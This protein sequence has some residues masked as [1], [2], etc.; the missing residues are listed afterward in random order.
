MSAIVGIFHTDSTSVCP[1]GFDAMLAALAHRGS[2]GT[3]QW[4][5]GPVALGQQ[6]RQ[7]TPESC[8]EQLPLYDPV[9]GLV[10]VA[11]CRLDNRHDLCDA[12]AVPHVQRTHTPDSQLLMLAYRK[13]ATH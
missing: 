7:V 4:R 9:T 5:V 13:W 6:H 8:H 2:D 10:L 11:D 1:D 12:L 3:G